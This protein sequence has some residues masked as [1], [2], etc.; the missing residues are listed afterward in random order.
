ML[1]ILD[2]L[3]IM[4]TNLKRDLLA[5]HSDPIGKP[6]GPDRIFVRNDKETQLV[7][8]G[9]SKGVGAAFGWALPSFLVWLI[10]G[11]HYMIQRAYKNADGSAV[12][13]ESM[14]KG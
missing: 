2:S 1:D 4:E 7:P 11:R 6:D 9:R 8:V 3:P 14:W 5:S 10:K 12:A 13:R